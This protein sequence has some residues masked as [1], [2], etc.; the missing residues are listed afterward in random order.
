MKLHDLYPSLCHKLSHF[1]RPLPLEHDILYGRVL[2]CRRRPILIVEMLV[3]SAVLGAIGINTE[4]DR[5]GT[6]KHV[7]TYYLPKW[8][9][10]VAE[11][12]K[13]TGR[14]LRFWVEG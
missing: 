13:N 3:L 14:E 12:G 9:K 10:N 6:E 8:R 5:K 11:G 2:S 1:L 7:I 4:K